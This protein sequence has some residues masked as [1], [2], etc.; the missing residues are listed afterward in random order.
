[1]S[2]QHA[3]ESYA[4]FI[5]GVVVATAVMSLFIA[6]TLIMPPPEDIFQNG[7]LY[8]APWYRF[9][10]V[11]GASGVFTGVV[12]YALNHIVRPTNNE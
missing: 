3:P 8:E 9:Y 4:L 6:N 7:V 1:M 12:A 10:L 5:V 2:D 11:I